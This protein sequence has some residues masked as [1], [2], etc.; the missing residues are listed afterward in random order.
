M[1]EDKSTGPFPASIMTDDFLDIAD[2][3]D[4]AAWFGLDYEGLAGMLYGDDL[5]RYGI[6]LISKKRGGYRRIKSP[7]LELKCVQ[8]QLKDE[9][10]RI[11][12][13]KPSAHGF[14][15]DRSIVTNARL[16]VGR[17][18]TYVFNLDLSAYFDSIHF[19]RI[20]N[21]FLAK[22]FDFDQNVA[23]VLA[24]I[25]CFQNAL[26]QGAPTSPIVANMITRKLD[27][28]LQ[29]LAKSCHATYSRYADDITFSFT[30][31]R[32]GLPHGIVAVDGDK[33]GPGPILEWLIKE[34]GFT[35][36]P[37]KVRLA[38]RRERMEVTGV[39][40][41]DFP[42]VPRA[43]VKQIGCML[44]SWETHNLENAERA[45]HDRYAAHHRGSGRPKSLPQVVRG[46]LLHL[47]NVRGA[48]DEIYAKLAR[49]FNALV[50]E[51]PG[52]HPDLPL[53]V[54]ARR[55][56]PGAADE[57]LTAFM[58]YAHE[59]AQYARELARELRTRAVDVWV[60]ESELQTGTPHVESI[61]E[62]I[63]THEFFVGIISASYADSSYCKFE[64]RV[65]ATDAVD[66]GREKLLPVLIDRVELPPV[67]KG[68][69][70]VDGKKERP[71]AVAK[72][73]VEAM[74]KERARLAPD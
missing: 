50:A 20:R 37:L 46:K 17:D 60:D 28:Q 34:N 71:A 21:L 30:C 54:Q 4:L 15:R 32:R 22:P 57:P 27:R 2:V 69:F 12:R 26:P 39:T 55:S 10:Y 38:D 9:L 61:S 42:N 25:C 49:R 29:E 11:Y 64:L 56:A 45:L 3:H 65:A 13:P 40:I 31:S 24:Q 23:T 52:E 8:R 35:V 74:L 19:G 1:V 59:D 72:A 63:V 44:H 73:L 43:Y 48:D 5:P 68:L 16:H 58:S 70:Y 36:N 67:V 41:N 18:K 53:G 51:L 33:I 6:F 47:R 7:C 66:K 62:Q 14:V